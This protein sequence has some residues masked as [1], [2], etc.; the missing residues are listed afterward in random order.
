VLA[1][2]AHSRYLDKKY[3]VGPHTISVPRFQPAPTARMSET[4]QVS[5]DDFLK[6][7][8]V[9]R[10]AVPYTGMIISTR[11]S[12][13]IRRAA[14][15]IGISQASAASCTTIG[16]YGKAQDHPQFQIQDERPLEEVVK[17]IV[18]EGYLP[19]FCTACYRLGRTGE[20]FMDISK[21][22]DIHKFCRPNGILTFAEYLED[23]ADKQLYEKGRS[24]IE[25]Y[26]S[27]I[28]D[29]ALREKTRTR[30]DEVRKGKRDV[31]F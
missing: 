26:L 5:D 7:I 12:A 8:A 18:K 27:R 9:L 4:H 10:L 21:A 31:Y 15:K 14:F 20:H 30:L 16:G 13:G 6:L 11:E 1:L 17:D 3:K 19:S 24:V 2:I 29:Q 25:F 28:H 23:F 22:G